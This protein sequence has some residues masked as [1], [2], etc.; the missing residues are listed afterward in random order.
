MEIRVLNESDAA[1][2]WQL[3]LEALETEPFA[4]GTDSEEHRAIPIETMALRFRN[5]P[6]G[7]DFTL[8]AFEGGTLV[9]IATFVRETRLK[10][11]HKGRICGVYVTPGQ[12]GRGLG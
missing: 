4:F 2:A 10:D 8:G 11:K 3:R 5:M 6:P 9:G 1:A 7:G 12:R